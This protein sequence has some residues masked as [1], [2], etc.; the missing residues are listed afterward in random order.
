[1]ANLNNLS[2]KINEA[3]R[4]YASDVRD[5]IEVAQKKVS[6]ELVKQL[7][8]KSPKGSR[9]KYQ[10]GWRM[11]QTSKGWIIHNKTDYQLTHLLEKGHAK[12]KGGRVPAKVHIR[13]EEQK[14]VRDYLQLVEQAIRK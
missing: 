3:L 6:K 12:V 5:D 13:P 1:M 7:K 10:K 8:M 2:S 9:G 11:K 14:T 4:A